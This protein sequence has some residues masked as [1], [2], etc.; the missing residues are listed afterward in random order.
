MQAHRW[1]V[2]VEGFAL[3]FVFG[4]LPLNFDR[5]SRRLKIRMMDQI[6]C[7]V[8]LVMFAVLAPIVC[9]I[10][11]TMNFEV[12]NQITNVLSAFQFAF[13]YLFILVVQL[14]FVTKKETLYKMLN[15]MF[16]LKHTLELVL[17][18]PML[19]YRLYSVIFV[20]IIFLDI[21][22]QLLSLYTFEENTFERASVV[23]TVSSMVFY[24]MMYY[25]TIIENFILLGLL[26][27]GVMQ[28][29]VN[30]IV[31]QMA[32]RP[33]LPK[34]R[35][36]T[37][38]TPPD[39]VQMYMLHCRNVEIANKFIN[40]LNFPTLML[41]GWYFFMIVYSVY[42]MYV[43]VFEASQRGMRMDEVKACTNSTIFFL[44]QCIQLYLIVL[45]PSVYT[46]Q[47][48]KMMRILNV[49]SA[50]QHQHRLAQ[51]RLFEVLMVDC[52]Q[53]NYSISNY[54][55][56]AMNRALLFGMIATMTSYLIILIQF[57]IQKY[58]CEL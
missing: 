21:I 50:N 46:D 23:L 53:R 41:T 17:S 13:I 52:M 37:I 35:D 58:Q 9:T 27:C 55:M 44:Y 54:G 1:L 11:Y 5:H 2:V 6:I 18:R 4:I 34:Q 20:K 49:V 57:H 39:L 31:K 47:A 25:I 3:K 32:R 16:D 30:M 14:M 48:E 36:S 24:G 51:D 28:V 22:M 45:V 8:C 10:L 40:T 33:V 43:F 26:I 38:V 15:E 42:Y 12:D 19:E 29:M 7:T 56:Y